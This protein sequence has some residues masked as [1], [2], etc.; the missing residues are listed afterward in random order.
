MSADV[1]S[2]LPAVSET[3]KSCRRTE[4]GRETGLETTGGSPRQDSITEVGAVKFRAG[5]RIGTFQTL[6][7]PGAP[8]P[9][10]ITH[11]TGIDDA[12]VRAAPPLEAVLPN[13]DEVNVARSAL[14][15][16]HGCGAPDTAPSAGNE[17]VLSRECVRL[18]SNIS[19]RGVCAIRTTPLFAI[20]RRI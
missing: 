8:I 11:L 17:H 4:K 14:G 16:L 3:V 10:F 9:P 15:E 1:E 5:E 6:V 19:R 20:G 13:V 7:D 12:T 2:Y 18:H